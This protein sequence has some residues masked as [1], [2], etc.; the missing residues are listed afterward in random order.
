MS[1]SM[2]SKLTSAKTTPIDPANIYIL[3]VNRNTRERLEI[4]PKLSMENQNDV[5]IVNF[6]HIS[7]LRI[8]IDHWK[9]PYNSPA[10]LKAIS[11]GDAWLFYGLV[12]QGARFINKPI[13][14]VQISYWTLCRSLMYVQFR[15]RIRWQFVD[16]VRCN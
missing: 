4:R 15:S 10:T 9:S 14:D 13:K 3:K 8:L 7:H 12:C 6:E 1:N 5:I 11:L 2:C 16:A